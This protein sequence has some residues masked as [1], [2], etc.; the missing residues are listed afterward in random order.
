MTPFKNIG[1]TGREGVDDSLKVLMSF[2]ASQDVEVYL[3]DSIAPMLPDSNC[4]VCTPRTLGDVC[5]LIIVLGGDGSLLGAVRSLTRRSVPILGINRGRLGFL[6]DILPGEIEE[7]VG[8]VLRGEYTQESRFLLSAQVMRN[9]ESIGRSEAFNDVVLN[10]GSSAQMIAFDLYIDDEFVYRQRSDGL[11]VATPT[12]STAYS[13][14]AGGPIMHP[15]LDAVVLVP[16]FPHTLSS[17]PI[18]VDGNSEIKIIINESKE[19]HLP[20]TCDG[21][22]QIE[23]MAGDIIHIKKRRNKMKLIHPLDHS[24]YASCRDKLGWGSRL[25][26]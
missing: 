3:C 25:G 20:V 5:D 14:S 17:R 23:T 12:G 24:F 2:L 8:A 1:I 13:L 21:Q 7:R 6:T 10:S 26:G 9:G 16:M 11:I 4:E 19:A 22:V 18:L 15:K